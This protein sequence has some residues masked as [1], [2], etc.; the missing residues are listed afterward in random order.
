MRRNPL[1]L[2][3]DPIISL[4]ATFG[5]LIGSL[6]AGYFA[7]LAQRY[8]IGNPTFLLLVSAT[9]L[10]ISARANVVCPFKLNKYIHTNEPCC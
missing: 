6:L 5:Q 4:G 9:C 8:S 1:V 3:I 10:V 7:T 2:L